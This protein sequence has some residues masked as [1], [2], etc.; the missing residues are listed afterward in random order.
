MRAVWKTDKGRRKRVNEDAVLVDEDAGLFLLADGMSVPRAGRVAS[1]LA[2][3]KAHA[4]LKERLA[5]MPGADIPPLLSQAVEY[6]HEAV[7]EASARRH[8][9]WGMG[10][11]LLVQHIRGET[12]CIGHVGDSRAYLLRKG[13]E[14]ITKDHILEIRVDQD[15][16]IRELFFFHRTRVLSRS[17]G[18][19][20]GVV[21]DI[22]VREL[23]P[24]DIML[25]CS[26]GLTDM[27][28]DETIGEI[29]V[30]FG[31]D[32]NASAEALIDAAN[33]MGGRDNISVVL[34]MV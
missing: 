28:S 2:V 14:L 31:S 20:E 19:S 26:D 32:I 7:R 33:R 3:R 5:K 10:T 11:T 18:S 25:L 6:A 17:L 30:S 21:G 34:I 13:L 29:M 1:R 15:V 24:G 12:A 16:M 8:L 9:L 23:Q 22:H 4:F 27:L